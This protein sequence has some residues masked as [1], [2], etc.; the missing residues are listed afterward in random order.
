MTKRSITQHKGLVIGGPK[1]GIIASC[2]NPTFSVPN[3][4]PVGPNFKFFE[5]RVLAIWGYPQGFKMFKKP[6]KRK[7]AFYFWV[8]S[9]WDMEMLYF[10]LCNSYQEALKKPEPVVEKPKRR[11]PVKIAEG[12]VVEKLMNR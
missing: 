10:H 6:P 11:R 9:T 3:G 5:Y 4:Q 1:D 7:D 2:P 12:S 8:P